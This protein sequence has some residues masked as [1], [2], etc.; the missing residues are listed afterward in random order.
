MDKYKVDW[1]SKELA[2]LC[3]DDNLL[4][5]S[6]ISDQGNM[7]GAFARKGNVYM[8]KQMARQA[9]HDARTL[10]PGMFCWQDERY[11]QQFTL[12]VA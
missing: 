2:E 4:Q 7:A 12:E 6:R 9:A 3:T 1:Y 5:R 11:G 8:A 10:F